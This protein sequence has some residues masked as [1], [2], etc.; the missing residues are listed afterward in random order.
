M[1]RHILS[2]QHGVCV[3][4]CVGVCACVCVGRVIVGEGGQGRLV[5]MP[6]KKRNEKGNKKLT[7]IKYMHMKTYMILHNILKIML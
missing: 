7:L 6:S 4:G 5:E 3:W 2:S 1:D